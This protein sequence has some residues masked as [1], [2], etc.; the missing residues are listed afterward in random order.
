MDKLKTLLASLTALDVK[1]DALLENP[2]LT[3]DQ[4]KDHDRLIAERAVIV[5][6]IDREKGRLAREQERQQLATA[7]ETESR[8]QAANPGRRTTPDVPPTVPA[9]AKVKTKKLANGHEVEERWLNDPR[10]GFDSHL[11]FL[12]AVMNAGRGGRVDSR[13]KPLA[14]ERRGSDQ[15]DDA[16]HD[17]GD[18]FNGFLVPKAFTP[19]APRSVGLFNSHGR[20]LTA[21]SDEAGTYSD[22]YGGF[23]TGKQFVPDLLRLTPEADPVGALTTKIP[24]TAATVGIPARVDKNHATSVSGGLRFYRRSETQTATSSRMELE[25]VELKAMALF[26]LAYAT[27]EL[28]SRSLISFLAILQAGFNDEYVAKLMRERLEGTGVG[29]YEGVLNT[30][31]IVS[32]A[33]ESGQSNDTIVYDNVIK[34]RARCWGYGNAVWLANH[35]TLPQLLKMSLAVGTGG[36]PIWFPSAAP[37]RPDILLG[38]PIYFSE[39]CPKLG[40]TGDLLLGNWKEYLEGELTPMQNEESMHVRFVE[41][42]RA[43]KFWTE[44]AGRCWWRSALTPAKSSDTLSPFVKLDAR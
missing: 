25:E 16:G 28:L 9:V 31:S 5:S 34:A 17:S 1:I 2:T 32:V 36:A 35:D 33:K 19:G 23:L 7:A 30:N 40:D 11:D 3:D 29:Q 10:K 12:K 13:L 4:E 14:Q 41:H 24:M 6:A 18:P 38:R 42:E 20:Q 37:D 27:E 22:P 8:R 26:G 44:N 43:F 15:D 39:F 21:G